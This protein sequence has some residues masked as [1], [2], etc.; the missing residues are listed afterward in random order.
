MYFLGVDLTEV[1]AWAAAGVEDGDSNY[2]LT[3]LEEQGVDFLVDVDLPEW[4]RSRW[5][6]LEDPDPEESWEIDI[7]DLRPK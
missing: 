2:V 1:P 3:Y 5:P 7:L 6:L 4:A